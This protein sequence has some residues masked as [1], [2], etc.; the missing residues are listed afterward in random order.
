MRKLLF[1]CIFLLSANA[2]TIPANEDFSTFF[3]RFSGEKTF[4]ESRTIYPLRVLTW[5]YGIDENG[6]DESAPILSYVYKQED[7]KHLNLLSTYMKENGLKSE[8]ESL[9][10]DA[11]VVHV[12]K[13]DTDWSMTYH[14][15]R[16]GKFWFLSE[17]QNHSL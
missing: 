7:E 8:I 3:S 15:S 13:E 11:A 2:C 4:A 1:F 5:E 14:F 12:F 6:K 17:F 10:P 9:T 16:K